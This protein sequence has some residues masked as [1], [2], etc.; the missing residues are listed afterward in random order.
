MSNTS[1]AIF[2]FIHM[3]SNDNKKYETFDYKSLNLAVH[4]TRISVDFS[5]DWKTTVLEWLVPWVPKF[6]AGSV[7]GE[8]L[9]FCYR[10]VVLIMHI[11]KSKIMIEQ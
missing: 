10:A 4:K 5:C 3:D 1:S 9:W 6:Y 11:I 2:T 8:L 7:M